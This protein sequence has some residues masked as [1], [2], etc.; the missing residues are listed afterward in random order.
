M[1]GECSQ[2]EENRPAAHRCRHDRYAVSRVL[3][4][5]MNRKARCYRQALG[6]WRSRRLSSPAP[7]L[8]VF[9]LAATHPPVCPPDIAM[10]LRMRTFDFEFRGYAPLRRNR[11]AIGASA[12]SMRARDSKQVMTALPFLLDARRSAALLGI[13]LRRFRDL[14]KESGFPAPRCL[15]PRSTRWVR[16]ELEEYAAQLPAKGRGEPEH[17]VAAREARKQRHPTAA[18]PFPP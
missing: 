6:Q 18:Y 10:R 9:A 12:H 14:C 11:C 16:V 8:A 15:G 7:R 2:A 5:R 13:S 4:H 17:L 3:G 1:L